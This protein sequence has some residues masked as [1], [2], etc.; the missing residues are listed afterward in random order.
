MTS[1]T[2]FTVLSSPSFALTDQFVNAHFNIEQQ[3]LWM[4]SKTAQN[5]MAMREFPALLARYGAIGSAIVD[6]TNLAVTDGIT[7]RFLW[8]GAGGGGWLPRTQLT[9]VSLWTQNKGNVC[10]YH[11]MVLL[12]T[13]TF[14]LKHNNCVPFASV[15]NTVK[16]TLCYQPT[17]ESEDVNGDLTRPAG[18]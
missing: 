1:S 9:W 15:T 11:G 4:G 5:M 2:S 13:C 3:F 18:I 16:D 10:F 8:S 17:S 6:N 7:V 12:E 14:W